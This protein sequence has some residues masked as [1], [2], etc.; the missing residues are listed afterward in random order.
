MDNCLIL[1]YKVLEF[2][3]KIK[4]VYTFK[5]CNMLT[6]G[7]PLDP[8]PTTRYETSMSQMTTNMC[9]LS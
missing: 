5:I 3:C 7:F 1:L 8:F 6:F 4:I 2:A 9:N